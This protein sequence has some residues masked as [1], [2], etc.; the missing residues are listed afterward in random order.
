MNGLMIFENKQVEIFNLNGKV[1]FNPKDV[2]Q[3][4]E[5]KNINENLRNMNSKQIVK[6]TNSKISSTE[7]RKLHNTGENFLTESGVY[8][9]IFKSRKKI[10]EKFQDWITDEV[11]PAIRE[12]RSY[13][14]KPLTTMDRL[15]LHYKALEEQNKEIH[16]VKADV[17]YLK[18]N[19]PLF[20]I[21]CKELQALVR[22]IGCKVL[23][24]YG[25]N[26]YKSN[27][28]R[29]KVYTDIQHQLKREFGVSRY[30][31][32]KRHDLL[33]AQEI[34]NKYIAPTYLVNEMSMENNKILFSDYQ[35]SMAYL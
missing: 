28:I 33:K 8:K 25:S 24:G 34:V 20:N 19:M 18:N 1:L 5:I 21:E 32:I 14:N 27:S 29:Q 15:K 22:K 6:L 10:A 13:T 31:A 26:A 12:R 2:A 4:L 35:T 30:E 16:E 11:L 23:G 17:T 9:L 7:F 3:C